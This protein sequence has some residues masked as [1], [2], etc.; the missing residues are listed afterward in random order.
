MLYAHI[1]TFKLK[2][3]LFCNLQLEVANEEENERLEDRGKG[4]IKREN[5]N[6]RSSSCSLRRTKLIYSSSTTDPESE[7][8][9]QCETM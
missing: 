9:R 1:A 8:M 2:L 6:E 4:D 5:G 3:L 7:A